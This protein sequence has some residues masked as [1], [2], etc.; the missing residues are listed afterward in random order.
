MLNQVFDR[1]RNAGDKRGRQDLNIGFSMG[2]TRDRGWKDNVFLDYRYKELLYLCHAAWEKYIRKSDKEKG[3]KIDANIV[4]MVTR[5]DVFCIYGV[6]GSG[7]SR[8]LMELR[9]LIRSGSTKVLP[10]VVTF[11]DKCEYFRRNKVVSGDVWCELLSRIAFSLFGDNTSDLFL[12]IWNYF[13]KAYVDYSEMFASLT[14]EIVVPFLLQYA[15]KYIGGKSKFEGIVLLVDEVLRTSN[16]RNDQEMHPVFYSVLK[17]AWDS[18]DL[19]RKQLSAI[20]TTMNSYSW[21][22]N[23]TKESS[24]RLYVTYLPHFGHNTIKQLSYVFDHLYF[25]L[26]FGGMLIIFVLFCFCLFHTNVI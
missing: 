18:D 21:I 3:R 16:A 17:S 7:K 8:F 15:N 5:D 4:K 6:P 9:S 10:I 23:K 24:R 14:W 19:S 12:Q 26:F 11:N 20:L 1:S 13:N 25:F 22:E 2:T